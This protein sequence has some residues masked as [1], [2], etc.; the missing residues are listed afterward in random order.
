M[1]KF[2]ENEKILKNLWA[3]FLMLVVIFLCFLLYK[4]QP[5]SLEL[6]FLLSLILLLVF[7]YDLY[8]RRNG[9]ELKITQPNGGRKK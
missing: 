3:Y 2:F 6:I 8:L 7:G 4:S 5:S 1:K 9:N